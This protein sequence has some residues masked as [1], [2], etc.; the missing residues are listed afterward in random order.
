MLRQNWQGAWLE[1]LVRA[2]LELFAAGARARV[3][4]P[5]IFLDANA[6]QNVGFALHELATNASK[7]GALSVPN[8]RVVVTWSEPDD[9]ARIRL[10][11][12]KSMGQQLSHR[13][14]RASA[15]LC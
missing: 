2:H 13:N 4:G 10:N 5:P 14:V 8:G 7:H 6:V 11:G 9:G 1:D 15:T 12:R 3:S